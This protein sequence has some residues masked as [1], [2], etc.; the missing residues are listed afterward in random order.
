MVSA[1]IRNYQGA[2]FARFLVRHS[3]SPA[4]VARR[5][6]VSVESVAHVRSGYRALTPW[7]IASL[8]TMVEATDAEVR[9][10]VDAAA[11]MDWHRNQRGR[12]HPFER[13]P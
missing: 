4:G 3:L 13:F 11:L 9:N 5:L 12:R 10:L 1:E 2:P 8:A 6:G 7:W